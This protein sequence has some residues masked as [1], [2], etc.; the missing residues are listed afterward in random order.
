MKLFFTLVLSIYFGHL[1]LH[2]QVGGTSCA[3]AEQ[4]FCDQIFSSST[5]GTGGDG[6]S[7][8]GTEGSGGQ[9]WYYFVAPGNG[10]VNLSLCTGTT[11]DSRIHVYTGNCGGLTC[12][13]QNDDACGLQSQVGW[14]VTSGVTYRIRIGGFGGSSGTFTANFTCSIPVGGC[15]QFNACNFNPSANFDDG[16]CSYGCYGCTYPAASNYQP[17]ATIDNGTCLFNVVADG[18]T[19]PDACN[20]CNLCAT[21]DGSCDYSCLG[22]TYSNAANY[23]IGASRDDGSCLF[24]GCTDPAALNYS[25]VA[26]SDNGS[27]QYEFPCQGDINNDGIIG[28]ADL[29]VFLGFFGTSCPN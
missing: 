25:A 19:D 12:L 28:V 6:V 3:A 22:C 15:T 17:T 1:S 5:P 7:S 9:R 29:I 23:A 10:N 2:A 21:D 20:Y 27:C 11:Y 13:A 4:I 24:S 18:C 16:S 26:L 8:C 14:A